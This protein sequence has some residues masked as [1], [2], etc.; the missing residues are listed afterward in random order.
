[1]RAKIKVELFEY[2]LSH[3]TLHINL[4]DVSEPVTVSLKVGA[5]YM[6][7]QRVLLPM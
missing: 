3:P 2:N 4:Y 5:L 6:Y 1:M 7:G